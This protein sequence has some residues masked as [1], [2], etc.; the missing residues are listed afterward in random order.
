MEDSGTESSV[1]TMRRRT[2]VRKSLVSAITH[3][4]ASVP[5]ELGH[6]KAPDI[7]FL[8]RLRRRVAPIALE[9]SIKI[10]IAIHADN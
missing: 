4:P 9:P 10:T 2:L 1:T 5:L 3:T 7:L 6:K 8:P